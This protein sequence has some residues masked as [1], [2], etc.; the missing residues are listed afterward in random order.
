IRLPTSHCDVESTHGPMNTAKSHEQSLYEAARLLKPGQERDRFLE[1]AC[2][3]APELRCRIERLLA[4][5][6]EADAFFANDPVEQAGL[7][8]ESGSATIGVTP[9]IE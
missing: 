8:D 9:A 6:T 7:I 2:A 5:A 4:A 3:D 1:A